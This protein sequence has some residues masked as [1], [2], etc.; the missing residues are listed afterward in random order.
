MR[1]SVRRLAL[2]MALAALTAGRASAFDTPP[3]IGDDSPPAQPPVRPM[4]E[5][6]LKD[7]YRSKIFPAVKA[8]L[9][10]YGLQ[11]TGHACNF[12]T[13]FSLS[14]M[15]MLGVQGAGAMPGT[16]HTFNTASTSDGKTLVL[17]ATAAQFFKEGTSTRSELESTG[18]AINVEELKKFVEDRIQDYRFDT[19]ENLN[20]DYIDIARGK[21]P[22]LNTGDPK[23][24][25]SKED[26]RQLLDDYVNRT[27]W[28][29]ANEEGQSLSKRAESQDRFVNDPNGRYI[30]MDGGDR[31]QDMR[32]AY[33][34]LAQ[35]L[36]SVFA[37][38]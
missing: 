18:L 9:G 16:T 7:L 30:D 2:L 10:S 23:T 37:S 4:S 36:Q 15:K 31:T 28:F 17:D 38:R 5:S 6:E 13:G 21:K 27:A 33:R 26:A 1:Q 12:G 34:V 20:M 22:P 32:A 14:G 24:S 35:N 29:H 19:G 25:V 3:P 11:V 8:A